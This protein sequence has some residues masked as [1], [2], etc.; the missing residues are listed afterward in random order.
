MELVALYIAGEEN[1]FVKEACINCPVDRF[2]ACDDADV[3]FDIDRVM[4]QRFVDVGEGIRVSEPVT[5]EKGLWC[6]RDFFASLSLTEGCWQ[7]IHT[8]TKIP[9]SSQTSTQTN[10][11]SWKLKVDLLFYFLGSLA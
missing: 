11:W 4:K 8:V 9:S 5:V 6:G 10:E 2:C 7:Y 1:F 3:L